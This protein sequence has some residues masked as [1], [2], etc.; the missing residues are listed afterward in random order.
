MS[1]TKNDRFV[2]IAS[3]FD[4]VQLRSYFL[5]YLYFVIGI[6]ILIFLVCFLG[7]LGPS[8]G[9]FPWKFYFFISFTIPVAI[10]FLLGVFILAFN[11][12][13]FGRN[14]V[15]EAGASDEDGEESKRAYMLKMNTFVNSMRQVPFLSIMFLMIIGSVIAYNLDAIIMLIL[16]A[17]E[18][19]IRYLLLSLG[20]LLVGALIFGICWVIANYKL[21]KKHME[22]HFKYK[23]DVMEHMG[24][25]IMDDET[26]INKEGKVISENHTKLIEMGQNEKKKFQILPPPN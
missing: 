16:N 1:N 20:I 10:T 14:M 5:N 26:V 13:L 24:L 3:L 11:K 2:G 15:E 21:R 23:N 25:L 19:V 8:N 18:K 9:P 12:Y 4:D 17:G 22:H 6:E 7:S